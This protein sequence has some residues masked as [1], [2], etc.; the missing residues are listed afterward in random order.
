M[1]LNQDE[2]NGTK[3]T[4]LEMFKNADLNK[5]RV[6]IQEYLTEVDYTLR[7][8]ILKEVKDESGNN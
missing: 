1:T 7:I 8:S 5:I 4:V 3:E 6:H 2:L